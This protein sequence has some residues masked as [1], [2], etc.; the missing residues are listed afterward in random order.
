MKKMIVSS[1]NTNQ[2]LHIDVTVNFYRDYVEA[3]SIL[4]TKDPAFMDFEADIL[5]ACEIHDFQLQDHYT[6]NDPDSISQYYVYI[7]TNEDNTK[8]KVYLKIRISDHVPEDKVIDDKLTS[9]AQRDAK[10]V[11]EKASRYAQEN[12]NQRRGYRARRIDVVFNDEHYTSYETAL[13]DIEN[14]LDEFDPE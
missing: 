12:F 14:K 6:S 7:K 13:R 2:E 3:D 5:T 10:Y 4:N 1:S 9:Y 8:L 11:K